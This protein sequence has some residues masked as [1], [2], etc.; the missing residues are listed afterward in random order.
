M[1]MKQTYYLRTLLICLSFLMLLNPVLAQ[2]GQT[3]IVQEADWLSKIAKKYYQNT[4][5]YQRIIEA[6]NEKATTDKSYKTI[7]NENDIS[8]GQKL[9][10]PT[11][12]PT[13]SDNSGESRQGIDIKTPITDCEIR[14]WY[15]YQVVA[16]KKINEKW[17][18]DGLAL[19][20]RAEMAYELRHQARMNARFMMQD[21]AAV[22]K[23]QERDQEKYGNPNGPTFDYLIK[24]IMKKGKSMDE[25]Y[26]G[27]IESSGRTSKVYNDQC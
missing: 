2:D 3:Y 24:K 14:I 8:V 5:D 19:K 13:I 10:I 18:A 1:K 17:K 23:L 11:A 25:A 15:N 21:K 6:T 9:W 4:S 26:E 20:V 22:K 12:A 7:K 27:I 16:I